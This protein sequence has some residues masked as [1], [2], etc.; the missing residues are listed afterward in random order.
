VQRACSKIVKFMRWRRKFFSVGPL[1]RC[2]FSKSPIFV[3]FDT[4][5]QHLC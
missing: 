1:V 2:D 5:V 4:E 3:K